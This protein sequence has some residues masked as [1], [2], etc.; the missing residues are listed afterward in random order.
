MGCC[1]W[2]RGEGLEGV[3]RR[4]PDLKATAGFL[5][6]RRTGTRRWSAPSCLLR[7]SVGPGVVT[8]SSHVFSSSRREGRG[9]LG[10]SHVGFLRSEM[11]VSIT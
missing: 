8:I 6:S 5:E 2:V 1:L 3:E 7:K 9:C 11:E 4:T 10:A